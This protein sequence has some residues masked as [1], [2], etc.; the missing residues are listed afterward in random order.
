MNSTALFISKTPSNVK[1]FPFS[2]LIA[3]KMCVKILINEMVLLFTPY[4]LSDGNVFTSRIAST[5][6]CLTSKIGISKFMDMHKQRKNA[7]NRPA[8]N[9]CDMR[10]ISILDLTQP[11][12]PVFQARFVPISTNHL[13]NSAKSSLSACALTSK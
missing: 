6:D 1:L 9:V 2:M 11:I 10:Y 5:F 13:K 8:I 7:E 4:Y 3:I 12:N